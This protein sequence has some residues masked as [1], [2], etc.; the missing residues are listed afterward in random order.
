MKARLIVSAGVVVGLSWLAGCIGP[1][2]PSTNGLAF[3]FSPAP[4]PSQIGQCAG[5]G[6]SSGSPPNWPIW[7]YTL[8]ITNSDTAPFVITGWS[9][10][11]QPSLA[12]SQV[13]TESA[14][15]FQTFF[16]ATQVP[17]NGSV[18]GEFC[19]YFA[20]GVTS[21]T[22]TMTFTSANA[23]VTTPQSLTLNP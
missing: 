4:V 2:G 6:V 3:K 8:T 17:G 21:G 5:G 7:L 23:S 22:L 20:T 18:T 14:A 15:A 19:T 1:T 10:N 13:L 11:L 9:I 12:A 16:G